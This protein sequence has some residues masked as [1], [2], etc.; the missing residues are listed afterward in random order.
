MLNENES[1]IQAKR[2]KYKPSRT[3]KIA[4]G[5][6]ISSISIGLLAIILTILNFDFRMVIVCIVSNIVAMFAILVLYVDMIR[7]NKLNNLN[8]KS[9]RR[10]I[11]Y[12]V[13]GIIIGFMW[14]KVL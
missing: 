10:M 13:L 3:G 14:G 2:I 8:E 6:S 11:I 5:I 7:F 1:S 4:F 12:L 9:D